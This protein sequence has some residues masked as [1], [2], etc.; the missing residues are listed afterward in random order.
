[1]FK[2]LKIVPSLLFLFSNLL[3]PQNNVPDTLGR[4]ISSEHIINLRYKEKKLPF[5][6][7][8]KVTTCQPSVALVLSGGGSRGL[9]Q[10]GVLKALQE[11]KIPVSSIVGTSMGSIL[12][13]LYSAGYSIPELDSIVHTI[14]WNQFLTST[15][16]ANRN[17]LFVDQKITEDKALITFRLEG[18]HVVL[19]TSINNGQRFSSFLNLLT[20]NAPIHV[21]S[22]FDELRYDYKAVCTDLI[23]GNPILLSKGSL[24]QAMRASSSVTLFISPVKQDS[25]LLVDGGLVA[26]IPVELARENG[27]ECVIAFNTTS[28]LNT[29]EELAYPWNIADQILSIP[30]RLLTQQQL[31]MADI[32]IAPDLG[33]KKNT[34]FTNIDSLIDIGY[35]TTLPF[36]DKIQERIN[37]ASKAKMKGK[38]VFFKNVAYRIDTAPFEKEIIRKYSQKDSVGS[39]EILSDLSSIYEDGDFDSLYAVIKQ[40]SNRSYIKLVPAF[41]PQVKHVEIKGVSLFSPVKIDSMFHSLE[42]KPYNTKKVYASILNVLKLYRKM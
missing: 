32:V 21:K 26:N 39:F 4:T 14:P 5:G 38:E 10:I 24:S 9:S 27:S 12:G 31:K 13:G 17:D 3:F 28:P 41:N 15:D 25:L 2:L 6:L 37:S 19:P 20:L 8:E 30:M 29:E 35:K 36:I 18:L 40:V 7:T 42:A 1:M 33:K 34:D 23:T 11:R 22:N 16:E